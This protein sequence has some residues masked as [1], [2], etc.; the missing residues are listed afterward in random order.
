MQCYTSIIKRKHDNSK[1]T[2]ANKKF[3]RKCTILAVYAFNNMLAHLIMKND[4][5]MFTYS[6]TVSN[7]VLKAIKFQKNDY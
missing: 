5:L 2:F 1:T 7:S 6:D 4:Q 3:M